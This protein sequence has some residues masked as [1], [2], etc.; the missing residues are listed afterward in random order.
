M[1]E[2][3][4]FLQPDEYLD[5]RGRLQ[6]LEAGRSLPFTPIRVFWIDRVPDGAVRGGHAHARCT[7]A[8][9]C[10]AGS[11]TVWLGDEPIRLS[12]GAAGVLLQ[13]GCRVSMSNWSD[14]AVLL[15]LA[16]ELYDPDEAYD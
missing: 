7:Q 6:V 15:V 4:P 11:L 10:V 2:H 5:E 16:D 13:P 8:L 3:S 1:L 9:F 12:A 14:D